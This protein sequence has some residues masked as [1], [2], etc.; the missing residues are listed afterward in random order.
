MTTAAFVSSQQKETFGPWQV[1]QGLP[2]LEEDR[3]LPIDA[4]VRHM[5]ACEV[6]DD[7]LIG[8]AYASE[9]ELQAMSSVKLTNTTI[10]MEPEQ[11]LFD[12]E[13]KAV[14]GYAHTGRTCQ[15][16][17]HPLQFP[18]NGLQRNPD[19]AKNLRQTGFHKG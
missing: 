5:I 12:S 16:V 14:Y 15:P 8:N 13:K 11:G 4:Q 2:T 17:L 18:Q 19:S 10:K 6:I 9:E 7:I 3:T 1:F